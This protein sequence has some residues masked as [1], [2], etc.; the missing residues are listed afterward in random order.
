MPDAAAAHDPRHAISPYPSA[1]PAPLVTH[2]TPS[3][4]PTPPSRGP[5][6]EYALSSEELQHVE[7]WGYETLSQQGRDTLM[8]SS[9]RLGNAGQA[10]HR[11]SRRHLEQTPPALLE[12][13]RQHHQALGHDACAPFAVD[14]GLTL[15]WPT[16]AAASLGDDRP[17]LQDELLRGDQYEQLQL[18]H[19]VQEVAALDIFNSLRL[20]S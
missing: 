11:S 2:R 16:E 1:A 12:A 8:H 9:L 13:T 15:E 3:V 18:D 10:Y 17:R 7:A 14:Q 4:A 19:I 6:R 5:H 20:I